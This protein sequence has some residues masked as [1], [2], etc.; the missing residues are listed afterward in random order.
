MAYSL[1]Q[2]T[3]HQLQQK[4]SMVL[5]Q[6]QI[7]AVRILQY[8]GQELHEYLTDALHVNPALEGEERDLCPICHYP[9]G[10]GDGQETCDCARLARQR[11]EERERSLDGPEDWDVSMQS[12]R[13]AGSFDDDDDDP[14][15]RV[16]SKAEYG[17]GLLTA[18]HTLI[19][20]EE[21]S[22]AEYLIGSLDSHGLLPP[23][24]VDDAAATLSV[25]PERVETVIAALQQLDPPGIGARSTREALLIQLQRLCEQGEPHPLAETLLRDHFHDIAARHFREI[26]RAINVT[27]RIIELEL[28]FI[29]NRLHPHPAH[30]FDPDLGSMASGAPPV[31]PDVV[32]RRTSYGFEADIVEQRRWDLRLSDSY[33]DMRLRMR[34]DSSIGTPDQIE[35]VRRSVEDATNLLAA[36]RQRWQTMQ[37][38][39][40]ALIEL[41]WD[42]LERG[43]AGLRPLTRKDVADLIGLHESTVSRAT[44][45]KYVLLPNGKTVPFDDFFNDSL[46][47]KDAI[48]ALIEEEDPRHPFSDEQITGMLN[49]QGMD[50]ARRTVAKYREEMGILPSRLRRNRLAPRPAQHAV[51]TS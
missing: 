48:T 51:V 2:T 14:L 30:G 24:I 22:I 50:V 26:A 1:T 49:Q 39:T 28:Q 37:R 12:V 20:V 25:A 47:V 45:G 42:Y 4:R 41:Q 3:E 38:V 6:N 21:Y 7:Q 17:A 9:I 33:R 19:D 13:G 43:P 8:P 18:L 29:A 31:R 46:L 11:S 23:T 27:P 15:V 40:D 35:Q 5:S 44:D 34:H 36:L 16:S 10:P 32:I